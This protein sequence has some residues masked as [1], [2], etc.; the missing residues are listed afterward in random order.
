MR[1]NRPSGSEGGA[2]LIQSSLPLLVFSRFAAVFFSLLTSHF[3]APAVMPRI[4][5]REKIT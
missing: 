5:C 3:T 2:I 4:S 1:E